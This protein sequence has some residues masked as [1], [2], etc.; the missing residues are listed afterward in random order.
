MRGTTFRLRDVIRLLDLGEAGPDGRLPCPRCPPGKAPA[1]SVRDDR[2]WFCHRCAEG[3]GPVRLAARAWGVSITEAEARL[4]DL[5][6]EGDGLSPA[7]LLRRLDAVA[8]RAEDSETAEEDLLL[9]VDRWWLAAA[10]RLGRRATV[11]DDRPWV[12]LRRRVVLGELAGVRE[13]LDVAGRLL[14]AVPRNER[15]EVPLLL[16]ESSRRRAR[17]RESEEAGHE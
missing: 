14:E 1:M 8:A 2:R 13:V 15:E 10:C 12:A 3:G 9:L 11:D 7:S 17:D 5:L 4:E 6:G 16:P